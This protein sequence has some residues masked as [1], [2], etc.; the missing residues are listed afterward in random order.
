MFEDNK[1]RTTKEE[2][3][4]LLAANFIREVEYST[5]LENVIMVK[6]S[7]NKWHICIDYTNLNNAFPK[8]PY[9]CPG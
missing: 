2:F 7:N 1:R 5:W 9:C 3:G 6:N 4:K 8:D